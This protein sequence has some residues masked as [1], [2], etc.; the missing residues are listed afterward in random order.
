M[1]EYEIRKLEFNKIKENIKLRIHSIASA[2]YIEHMKPLSKDELLQEQ[3]LVECFMWLLKQKGN[4]L[5]SFDDISKSL[6]K[7]MIEESVLGA[8]EIIA[9]YKVLKIIKDVR[10]FLVDSLDRCDVLNRILK[11]L[12]TFQTLEA[13]IERTID[14]S[15]IIKSEASRDLLEIRKEIKHVEKTITEKLEAL[16]QRPDSDTLFSE[17]LI[18]LR[19]NRYVVPVKTQSVKRIVGIVHGVSSS[20]FTTYLEPQI[21]VDLNNKLA[22]LRT[23]EEKEIHL[24]LKKLTSVIRERANRLLDSFNTVVKVDVLLAKASFGI[25]YE[26]SIPSIGDYVELLGARNPIMSILS[27][28]P[29]P[30]DIILNKKGL[31][32]TGP[33]TGGKTVFL[34]TLGLCYI[35]FLHAI[36]IPVSPKSRLPI[37]DNI[38]ADIGDEQD[39][40]QSLSTFSSHIKNISEILQNSTED[41]LILL[42]EL[43]AGTDPLEGSALGIAILDYIKRLN[44]FVVVST[45]HTPIKLWAVNSDY[46]EPA[47][48]MFDKDTLRPLYRVVYGTIGE[49]MGIEVAR[50]FG[51][52]KDVILE[53][54]K[55]LGENTL[56]YQGLMEK[57]N[58][59]TKEYHDKM[60]LLEKHRQELELLKR[61]YESLIEE[62]EKAKQE[63]WKNTVKEANEYL[64]QLRKEAQEFL[65]GLKE[66]AGLKD[67]IKQKQEELRK[68]EKEEQEPIEVGDWVEFMGGK[69][70]VLEIRQDKAQVMFGDIKA[71]IKL[72]DL[73]KTAKL[74]KTHTTS[75]S[76]QRFENK[77]AGVPEINLTGLSIEEAISKL[78][79]FLD[80][81]FA[82]GV[83]MAKII[84][85][86]GVLKKAVTDYLSSS[87]YVVFYRDAYP[88]EGGQGTTVVYF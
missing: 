60:E 67:F 77:K 46:Y 38:F 9:I 49:S 3:K 12:G 48:L 36:P 41:S 56:E 37:F 57:L 55:L 58:E 69:G 75:I 10:K 81:A 28:N 80:S 52:P 72:K 51:I 39:I 43:G 20:G 71:W 85:G 73:S 16:F 1:R 83:K 11:D 50:R 86:L 33:N 21:V 19:Q 2:D 5:Y 65:S 7:A 68:F 13:E 66:K 6:K 44:A 84:H 78:D 53:A 54:Q 61:K 8:D 27:Q 87:S 47:T 70:R 29:V 63:A 25:E 22:M 23:E 31:V 35:M 15:G 24:V 4:V 30:I 74:P 26:C 59:L 82:S 32:L 76:L 14:P 88:K 62:M 40:S 17:K 42:D 64:E 18:T 34:K 79:K 45:H